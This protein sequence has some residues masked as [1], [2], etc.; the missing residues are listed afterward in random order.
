MKISNSDL[1][2]VLKNHGIDEDNQTSIIEQLETREIIAETK[3]SKEDDSAAAKDEKNK[4]SAEL[5][6]EL[7]YKRKQGAV[8]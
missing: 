6:A 4:N 7:G 5:A 2:D 3:D 8:G 1:K